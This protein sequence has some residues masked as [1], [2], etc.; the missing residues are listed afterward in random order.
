LQSI[1]DPVVLK[2]VIT[3]FTGDPKAVASATTTSMLGMV[4]DRGM[5]FAAPAIAAAAG[6]G[7]LEKGFWTEMFM[8]RAKQDQYKTDNYESKVNGLTVGFDA[9]INDQHTLGAAVSYAN[10][11]ITLKNM[12]G[13]SKLKTYMLTLYGVHDLGNGVGVNTTMF[14][15]TNKAADRVRKAPDG[16]RLTDTGIAT[17]KYSVLAYGFGATLLRNFY[18]YDSF[19]VTPFAGLHLSKF[20]QSARAEGGAG[21]LNMQYAAHKSL[22]KVDGSFGVRVSKVIESADKTIVPNLSASVVHDLLGESMGMKIGPVGGPQADVSFAPTSKTALRVNGGVLV[23]SVDMYDFSVN[24]GT[25]FKRKYQE[26]SGSL[27]VRVAL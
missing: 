11:N 10:T 7:I 8:S 6:D 16:T 19:N 3:S 9:K 1:Q 22:K 18:A 17:A 21:A 26:Y 14:A 4:N 12:E 24:L 5:S 13:S 2:K 25:T 15:A 20:Q 27:K 23:K